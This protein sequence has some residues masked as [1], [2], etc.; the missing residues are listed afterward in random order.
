VPP[1]TV[2]PWN[3]LAVIGRGGIGTVYR[4][5]HT[6]TG[7]L[8][9][10]KLLGP[11]PAVDPTAARRL[12]REY[13]ALRELEHPNI[14]RVFDAGAC[15]G[16][17][18]LAMELIEGLDLRTYLSPVLDDEP[19]SEADPEDGFSRA[20]V[21]AFGL[22]AW[23]LEP[24]TD[25]LI[26]PFERNGLSNGAEDIRAF[27]DVMEEPETDPGAGPWSEAGAGP[28]PLERESPEPEPP[29]LSP[30]LVARLNRPARLQRLGHALEQVCEALAYVHGRG[31]VHRDLKPS[32]IMVD[33][34]RRAR[35]MDFGLVK[36]VDE[37][38]SLTLHGRV[39]GTYRY[40]APEQAQGHAVDARSDL[41]SLGVILYE[42]L[43]GRPPS[44]SRAP[45]ELWRDIVHEDPP[46]IRSLNPGADGRLAAVAERLL[47][48]DPSERFQSAQDVLSA[49]RA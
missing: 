10:V 42:L 34:S 46:P 24:A 43:C 37:R 1:K 49:L 2:G 23:S 11:A 25:S 45:A 44:L 22:E 13:E 19:S 29:P 39:V 48:K 15:G 12:A 3:I 14:V 30:Q 27:A 28:E 7:A 21:A 31:F 40:M 8:A 41:Y 4:A 20:E 36:P 9:A 18:Y 38:H 26:A 5:R 35:I 47:R 6:R 33:E 16:Y 17:S 32:N